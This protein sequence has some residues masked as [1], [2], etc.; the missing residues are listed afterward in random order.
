MR[1]LKEAGAV[2]AVVCSLSFFGC[3]SD[4]PNTPPVVN[5]RVVTTIAGTAGASGLVNDTGAAARFTHPY[6][7]TKI[8]GNLYVADN[9][10]AIRKIV[11]ATGAVTTLAGTGAQGSSDGSGGAVSF[12]NP[13]GITNDGT[14]L[15]VSDANNHTIRK[16]DPNTNEVTTF[17]GTAGSNG[18]TNG[19]G[20]A[21]RFDGPQGITCD[22][23]NLYVADSNNHQIRKIVI[24]TRQVST[25]ASTP[26]DANQPA[27]LNFPIGLSN[28][29]TYLYVTEFQDQIIL[30]VAI[31]TGVYSIVAGS[32]GTTG[33]TDGSG[34]GATFFAPQGITTNG[35]VA[36]VSDTAN[37]TIRKIDL[38]TKAVTT[39]AGTAGT[40]G[41]A[42]G[43]GSDARFNNPI[44]LLLDGVTLYVADNGNGTI[45]MIK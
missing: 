9:N 20:P 40:P 28:D 29:G 36:Y 11:L 39:F 21:A 26:A 19:I 14:Y 17:A 35:S 7:I 1:F 24:A 30:K 6:G 31:G 23:T 16:I 4:N 15:Y 38:S 42:N 5:N 33:H 44:G 12:Y 13:F 34:A 18:S 27:H 22:G 41:S 25:I 37:H 45:R 2:L 43:T 3:G 32:A 10:N 8:G